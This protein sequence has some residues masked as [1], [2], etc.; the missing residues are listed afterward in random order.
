MIRYGRKSVF[1]WLPLVASLF[2][3]LI[4]FA[5]NIVMFAIGNFIV[6]TSISVSS[7]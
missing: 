2:S 5:R 7:S 4:V 3:L 1:Y 6:G